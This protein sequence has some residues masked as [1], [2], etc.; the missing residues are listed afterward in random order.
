MY[1]MSIIYWILSVVK[2]FKYCED[3]KQ[4]MLWCL[5]VPIIW[6]S[7]S[8]ENIH[9]KDK[10]QCV[11]GS[12]ISVIQIN[13]KTLIIFHNYYLNY[14]KMFVENNQIEMLKNSDFIEK[15]FTLIDENGKVCHINTYIYY[16][17]TTQ[18]KKEYK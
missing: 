18:I 16:I 3:V 15:I 10:C 9:S 12:Q 13:T 11:P 8:V 7:Q 14:H 6:I 5:F 2:C 4:N 17:N 1:Q